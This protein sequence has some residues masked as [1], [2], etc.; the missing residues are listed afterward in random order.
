LNFGLEKYEPN[1]ESTPEEQAYIPLSQE[2][3]SMQMIVEVRLSY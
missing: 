2:E 3:Q 1:P